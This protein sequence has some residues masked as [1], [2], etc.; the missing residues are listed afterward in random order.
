MRS[1]ND[2]A[3]GLNIDVPAAVAHIMGVADLMPELRTL[4]A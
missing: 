4:A 2:R 1:I 3:H